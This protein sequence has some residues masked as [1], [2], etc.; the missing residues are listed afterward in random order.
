MTATRLFGGSFFQLFDCVQQ[1]AHLMRNN[2]TN[3]L[4]LL[5][6]CCGTLNSTLCCAVA[7]AMWEHRLIMQLTT[8]VCV[9]DPLEF[10]GY[11]MPKLEALKMDSAFL[12][13]NVNEGFSGGEKK[14][15]EVRRQVFLTCNSFLTWLL[16][17][18]AH[19]QLTSRYQLHCIDHCACAR[20]FC[21]WRCWKLRSQSWTR[22]TQVC[23]AV[24]RLCPLS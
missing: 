17:S 5:C 8:S 22:S 20:R 19:A 3:I 6:T 16:P 10:Y 7:E 15:N 14:R 4:L 12:N 21:S 13:R 24:A 1:W 18:N 9:Q 23:R 11:L 2:G